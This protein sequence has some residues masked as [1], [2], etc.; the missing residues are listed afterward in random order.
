MPDLRPSHLVHVRPFLQPV[1][2]LPASPVSQ[3]SGLGSDSVTV[4]GREPSQPPPTSSTIQACASH[5]NTRAST[6]E[7]NLQL[8]RDCRVLCTIDSIIV[9]VIG[10]LLRKL[11]NLVL[12]VWVDHPHSPSPADLLEP[13]LGSQATEGIA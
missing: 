7:I 5:S 8:S 1:S 12:R 4:H 6:G 3:A 2:W 10:I 13:A 9:G 11:L